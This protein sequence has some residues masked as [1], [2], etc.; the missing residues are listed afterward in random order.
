VN[1]YK[2][3]T[4]TFARATRA[5]HAVALCGGGRLAAPFET[6]ME[7]WLLDVARICRRAQGPYRASSDLQRHLR[8]LSTDSCGILGSVTW[9]GAEHL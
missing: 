6:Y 9:R 3:P 4:H 7:E 2:G 5:L 8:C 1:L